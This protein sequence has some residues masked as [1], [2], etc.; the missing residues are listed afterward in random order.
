[1]KII[2][3]FILAVIVCFNSGLSQIAVKG[4]TIYTMS[5]DPIEK[6]I[7]L[8]NKGK[9]E[10]V[11]RQ[12]DVQ[13]PEGYEI[14][15]GKVITPGLIDART[16]VGLSGI[17]NY[18][19]DQDQLEKSDAIQ[20]EL[21]AFDAY[22]KD[23]KLVDFLLSLGITTIH[24]GHGPGALAS[25]QTM[26]AK[27]YSESYNDYVVDS[28]TM[29]AFT[30]GNTVRSNYTKP[31]TRSKGVAM[32]RSEFLKAQEYLKK[33]N[34]KDEKERPKRDLKLE[35]LSKVL[36]G[37]VRALFTVN[38]AVDIMAALRLADEFGFKPVLDG[39]AEGYLLLDELKVRKLEIIL[40]PTMVR[41]YG[42][43]KNASLETPKTFYE[44]GILFSL[45][46][47]YESYVPK[48]RVVLFEAAI[49]HSYGLPFNEA[50][51]SITINPAKLLGIDESVG[52]LEEGKFADIVVFDG[53]PFEY[54]SHVCKVIVKGK[55]VK[56][57]CF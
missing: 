49:A 36:N 34:S 10:K 37:D 55:V 44:A 33:Q 3:T 4:E 2:L 22:N 51:A 52:S 14:L 29:V 5:G 57:E 19:H 26:I 43:T 9:I 30:L 8:I 38:R 47:G 50:L 46:S 6:G 48:T 23:E 41:T 31:G 28:L 15:E 12:S 39:V 45:Q 24:T 40:H 56:D 20:P 17:Y 1:M 16:V 25:G 42:D 13:I 7:V 54:T 35:T 18:T 53:N 11:G 27:T 21:R 32:L